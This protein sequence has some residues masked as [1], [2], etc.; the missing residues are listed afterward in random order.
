MELFAQAADKSSVLTPLAERLR[1][2]RLGYVVGQE[3]LLG[4]GQFLREVL[5]SQR[6]PS[7]V[8][9]GPPGT[10]KTTIARLLARETGAEFVQLSAVSAGVKDLRAAL[11]AADQRRALQQQLT[12]LFIDAI[13]RFNKAQH[14]ALLHHVQRVAVVLI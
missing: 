6:L 3:H 8:L 10:G 1:P 13:H 9:W 12:N 7:I 5:R 2:Q 11:E 4:E 14:D